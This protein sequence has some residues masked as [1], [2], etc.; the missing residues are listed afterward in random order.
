M[1]SSIKE[2]SGYVNPEIVAKNSLQPGHTY[3]FKFTVDTLSNLRD[4]DKGVSYYTNGYVIYDVTDSVRL[5]SKEN[6]DGFVLDNLV[7]DMVNFDD[8]DPKKEWFMK[9]GSEMTS[10]A[11]DGVV[12]KMM[13][14]YITTLHGDF[15][16]LNSGW[17]GGSAPYCDI[18]TSSDA[19]RY[20]PW[21]Y[22]FIFTGDPNTYTGKS[23]AARNFRI[24]YPD[25]TVRP[26]QDLQLA[27]LSVPFMMINKTFQTVDGEFDT[28][29]VMVLDVNESGAFEI[30]GDQIVFG[31]MDDRGRWYKSL[32]VFNFYEEPQ[33]NDVYYA[34]FNRP[35][36]VTD[37]LTW[38]ILPEGELDE[39]AI[40]EEMENI[41]VVPNPYVATNNMEPV[42]Q[43]WR[44]NQ[45]RQIMFTHVPAQCTI[46]IFT[47]SG[48]FVDEVIVDNPADDGIAH[49]DVLTSES[50]EVAAGVYVYHVKSDVTGAEKLGKFAIIK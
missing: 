46:K 25:S 18:W 2:S 47:S 35:H 9:V 22:E 8:T 36:F 15:D 23:K 28:L 24:S 16:L 26:D 41:K 6:P 1:K 32:F 30:V 17:V 34:T 13:S 33:P 27:Q 14:N 39:S 50:L 43:N 31:T 45:R 3:T 44:R 11:A 7:Y 4:D 40:D 49:W 29:D 10:D 5:V 42:M 19:L 38:R 21:D 48:V 12:M 37:S 20:Y